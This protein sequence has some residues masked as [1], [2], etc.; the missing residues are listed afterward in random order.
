MLH[1]SPVIYQDVYF[2]ATNTKRDPSQFGVNVDITIG[3]EE[4][5]FSADIE[6]V[7]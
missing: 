2:S 6:H 7:R 4:E 5:G 3:L 1:P